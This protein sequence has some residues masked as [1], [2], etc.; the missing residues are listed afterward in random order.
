MVFGHGKLKPES[1]KS[2]KAKKL[3]ILAL[4]LIKSTVPKKKN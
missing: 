1:L 3:F 2:R 4:K